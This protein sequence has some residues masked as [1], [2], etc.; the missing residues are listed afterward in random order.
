MNFNL[1]ISGIGGQGV[2][3]LASIIGKAALQ[4]NYDIK[5]AEL[6]GLSQRFGSLGCH[7]RFGNNIHSPLVSE[8]AA[9]LL[10]AFERLEVLHALKYVGKKTSIIMGSKQAVPTVLYL[11]NIKYPSIREVVKQTKQFTSDISIIDA[12]ERVLS[13]GAPAVTSNIYLLGVAVAEGLLPLKEKKILDAMKAIMPP[14]ILQ[15]NIKIFKLGLK[16][17]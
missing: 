8:A 17:K 14:K 10:I 9:D 6:H 12:T 4:S 2:L 3:T 1:V 7:I 11:R 5:V 15:L 13:V 16:H